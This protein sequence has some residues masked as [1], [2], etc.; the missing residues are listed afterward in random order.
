MVSAGTAAQSQLPGHADNYSPKQLKRTGMGSLVEDA[1]S[2]PMPTATAPWD[3]CIFEELQNLWGRTC[4][5]L[6]AVKQ[7]KQ[8]L[9][10]Q[11]RDSEE[12]AQQ[13]QDDIEDMLDIFQQTCAEL[14]E[15][16]ELLDKERQENKKL[17]D[18]RAGTGAM[19][20]HAPRPAIPQSVRQCPPTLRALIQRALASGQ[21]P[22]Q[23]ILFIDKELQYIVNGQY[24]P[25]KVEQK[26]IASVPS[27]TRSDVPDAV[28]QAPPTLRH[29]I[30]D[31]IS[32]GMCSAQQ[33]AHIGNELQAM[34]SKAHKHRA[35]LRNGV[36]GPPS[37]AVQKSNLEKAQEE[38][39]LGTGSS[40]GNTASF[41]PR[42]AAPSLPETTPTE[43]RSS[44]QLP[45]ASSLQRTQSDVFGELDPTTALKKSKGP[46][47]P[48]SR[49]P[50][51]QID[52]SG[53]EDRRQTEFRV[54][55]YIHDKGFKYEDAFRGEVGPVRTIGAVDRL[56]DTGKVP[57]NPIPLKLPDHQPP[58]YGLRLTNAESSSGASS[59]G[60]Q[61][62]SA[63]DGFHQNPIFGDF[64]S[65]PVTQRSGSNSSGR[66]ALPGDYFRL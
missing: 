52:N 14:R 47:P 15:A 32:N 51:R 1:K 66:S 13:L 2:S 28:K 53:K 43:R 36:K 50:M 45:S 34:Y 26:D 46:E 19:A 57:G 56:G 42:S 55:P 3:E 60:R 25:P 17:R 58:S 23:K 27:T 24:T 41:L 11:L 8:L 40:K 7:E 20:A 12:Q 33:A 5:E 44:L 65:A 10:R 62:S 22:Q 35:S 9:K 61:P 16:R 30:D 29:L 64:I 63:D 37:P 39:G 54:E 59:S 31:S 48:I 49:I 21:L 6:S 38:A 18:A 4:Q